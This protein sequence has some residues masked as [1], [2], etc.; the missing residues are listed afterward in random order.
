MVIQSN[1]SHKFPSTSTIA[2]FHTALSR[3]NNIS[4]LSCRFESN[5]KMHQARPV[6][7]SLA[8]FFSQHA[9]AQPVNH[10]TLQRTNTKA[11]ISLT[12]HC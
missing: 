11:V 6:D 3:I 5:T 8:Q 1:R 10:V 12:P 2:D 9:T 7:K 4:R